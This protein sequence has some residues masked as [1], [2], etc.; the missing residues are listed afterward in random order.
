METI[1]DGLKNSGKYDLQYEIVSTESERGKNEPKQ[2]DLGRHGMVILDAGGEVL[3]RKPGHKI[4]KEMIVK[5][6]Q[7]ALEKHSSGS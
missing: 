1:V 7:T 2:Y 4:G 6:I 5:G 3:W